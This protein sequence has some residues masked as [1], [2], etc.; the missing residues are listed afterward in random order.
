[1]TIEA[2]SRPFLP[3][4]SIRVLASCLAGLALASCARDDPAPP[5]AGSPPLDGP[6][7][8]IQVHPGTKRM[9][10]RLAAIAD[11]WDHVSLEDEAPGNVFRANRPAW[12]PE[13]RRRIASANS[14]GESLRYRHQLARELLRDGQ[15]RAALDEYGTIRA[16]VAGSRMPDATKAKFLSGIRDEVSIALLRAAEQANCLAGHNPQSCIFPLAGGGVH[17]DPRYARETIDALLETLAERPDD[18]GARWL[19]EIASQA[20]DA[21]SAGV[22]ERWRI[23]ATIFA[24]DRE[25]PRF[26]ERGKELGI[27]VVG[28]AGGCAV[29]DFNGDGDLDLVASSC[30][31]RDPIRLFEQVERG[32]F[33]ERS[34][35]AGLRGLVGGLNLSHA[36]FDNDGDADLFVLRGGWLGKHGRHPNSL[37]R[38]RGD[39]TFDDITEEAGILTFRPSQTVAWADFDNDGW[40][41]A[42]VGN[43]SDPDDPHPCELYRNL[44]NGK[45]EE[46]AEASGLAVFGFV[47]GAAWGDI[48]DDRFPDLYVSCMAQPNRL[49]RNLG[50]RASSSSGSGSSPLAGPFGWAFEDITARAGVAE[51][52]FSFPTW[53]WDFDND[54][55]L[56]LFVGGFDGCDADAICA[57]ALGRPH[58]RGHPRLYRNLGDLRFEDVTRTARLDRLLLVMGAGFGDFDGDGWLDFYAGTG[59]PSFRALLPNRLFRNAEGRVFEDVTTSGG[60]GTLQKGH[61]VAFADFDDDG[62]Q[63]IYAVIGGWFTGD[64]YPNAY[65]ENPGPARARVVLRLRGHRTNRSAIGARIRV[66]AVDAQGGVREVHRVVSTGGSFGSTT[67]RQEI[68]L[69]AAVGVAEVE[70]RWPTSGIRQTLEVPIGASVVVDEPN[71]ARGPGTHS[72]EERRP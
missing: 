68:G 69:G 37:L 8:A 12:I 14:A 60:V 52:I 20:A 63:D 53:F 7:G 42:F 46:C 2:R 62:D 58:R 36:D 15:S 13:L 47:K 35:L 38:N 56:D 72:V 9:V 30:G 48:D 6:E 31:F 70:I 45:F 27:D 3:C 24:S 22:P 32:R 34:D 49:Y 54:G 16:L 17:R 23:P 11:A 65:F 67:L 59:A 40:L 57:D 66:R 43:E 64:V 61:G 33:E 50:R 26:I 18:L 71:D 10:D 19:L 55:R 4:W 21:A 1:V 28:L 51:P 44:G 25:I 39:G 29:E 41:D 5:N